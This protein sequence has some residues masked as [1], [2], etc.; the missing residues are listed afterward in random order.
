M[1]LTFNQPKP[2]MLFQAQLAKTD[3]IVMNLKFYIGLLIIYSLLK[4]SLKYHKQ[5]SVKSSWKIYFHIFQFC[6][7]FLKLQVIGSVFCL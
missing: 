3:C 2:T 5:G 7:R 1:Y 6:S 4:K